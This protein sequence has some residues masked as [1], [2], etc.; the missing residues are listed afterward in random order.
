MKKFFTFFA[1]LILSAGLY[2]QLQQDTIIG[3]S[4]PDPADTEFNA[5]TG[6]SGNLGYDIRAEVASTSGQLTVSLSEGTGGAGDYAATASGWDSGTDDK[7]WSI[8]F[9][10][11]GYSN[12]N[13]SSKQSTDAVNPGPRDWKLQYKFGTIDWTDVPNG[14]ITVSDNWSSGVITDLPLPSD[15]DNPGTTSIYI[16]WIMTSDLDINGSTLFANGIS[17]IDDILVKAATPNGNQAIISPEMVN[18]YPNP[19]SGLFK[20]N[21]LNPGLIEILDLT[22][23]AVYSGVTDQQNTL[24]DLTG[25]TPGI[26]LV[27]FTEKF[28]GLVYTDRLVIR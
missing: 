19:T 23:K 27:K 28:S 25:Q 11:N 16:R 5:N 6:L 20:I 1:M 8:K 24:L 12:F 15:I 2:A 13:L 26:Y 4:F 21:T 9:K 22:G 14:V 3:W 10:A 17:R 18:I 7:F